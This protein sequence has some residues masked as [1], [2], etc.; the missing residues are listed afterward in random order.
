MLEILLYFFMS[1]IDNF[2]GSNNLSP[3]TQ[4]ILDFKGKNLPD[5]QIQ[6][7]YNNTLNYPNNYFIAPNRWH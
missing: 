1:K 6:A 4:L 7:D 2:N 3:F 5:E